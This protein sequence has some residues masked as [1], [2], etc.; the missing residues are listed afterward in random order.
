MIEAMTKAAPSVRLQFSGLPIRTKLLVL[1]VAICVVALLISAVLDSILGWTAE[2]RSLMR[3]MQV[4]AEIVSLQSRPALEFADPVAARENLATLRADPNMQLACLYDEQGAEFAFYRASR[5][6][7]APCPSAQPSHALI[8]WDTA[9]LFYPIR[10]NEDQIGTFYMRRNM[11]SVNQR[12]IEMMLT[13]VGILLLAIALIW[14]LSSY[15]QRAIS[16]PIVNLAEAS[17][18]FSHD[19]SQARPVAKT[20]ND[21]I[22]DLVDAFNAMMDEIR[23]NEQQLSQAIA[24]LSRSNT[25]LER[26]AYICSHDLQEPLRMVSNYANLLERKI[27]GTLDDDTRQY[28]F[29]ITDGAARMRELISDI[30]TYSRIGHH[31]EPMQKV[32]SDGLAEYVLQNLDATIKER[33]AVIHKSPLPELVANKTL[34]AQIFQNLLS[35][36]VKFCRETPEIWI[37][38][39]RDTDAWRFSIRDNGIGIDPKYHD[40]IFE[41]FKR[42]NRREEFQGTGIGLAICKKAVEYHGGRIWV[43][44]EAGKGTTF[45]FT[46]P[47]KEPQA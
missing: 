24:E 16:G 17:R 34:L 30:L 12:L 37:E 25:E 21:E 4:T 39:S 29:F 2:R 40:K 8:S 18:H 19:R 44:S 6:E 33:Q 13:K 46:I 10:G 14:P 28:L 5:E 15:F 42:L 22:G 45:F 38:A 1:I 9:E 43:E 31:V 11:Q 27:L 7:A 36:A 41:I 26:F 3:R 35:N 47:D 32:D 23:R 20:S